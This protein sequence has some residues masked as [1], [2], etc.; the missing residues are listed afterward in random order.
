[1]LD[2]EIDPKPKSTPL[3][4]DPAVAQKLL[5]AVPD[6]LT[7]IKKQLKTAQELEGMLD[8]WL[9]GGD[10]EKSDGTEKGSTTS[11]T[12]LDKLVDEVAEAKPTKKEEKVATKPAGDAKQKLDAAFDELMEDG[13]DE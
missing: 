7:Y 5:D 9:N 4:A 13:D 11:S 6:F 8:T 3:H 12:D 2:T 10:E 1:V